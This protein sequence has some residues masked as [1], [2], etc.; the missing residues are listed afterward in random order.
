MS[1]P[2]PD[3]ASAG[4]AHL[5]VT[6]VSVRFGGVEALDGVDLVAEPGSIVGLIGPNG[7]GK[8]TL[9]NVISGLVH[10]RSR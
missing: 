1:D 6:C 4:L 10:P 8:T 5:D 9:L 3:T 7:S 2:D